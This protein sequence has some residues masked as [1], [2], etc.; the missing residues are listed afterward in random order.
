MEEQKQSNKI[1]LLHQGDIKPD[2]QKDFPETPKKTVLPKWVIILITVL[3]I[4][5]IGIGGY[6]AYQYYFVSEELVPC[7]MEVKLCPDGTG[8]GRFPPDCEFEECPEVID[9]TA[10]WQTYKNEEFGF[11]LKYPISLSLKLDDDND[12]YPSYHRIWLDSSNNVGGYAISVGISKFFENNLEQLMDDVD[13]IVYQDQGGNILADE[14]IIINQI[15]ARKIKHFESG[16][17]KVERTWI[18]FSNDDSY[19]IDIRA[20]MDRINENTFNQILSTFNLPTEK[21]LVWVEVD[22]VQCMENSWEIDWLRENNNDYGNYPRGHILV[23]EE[24]EKE[25]IKKY[26]QKQGIIIFN[27]K[28]E[29][30]TGDF[31]VCEACSCSQGYTLYLQ[32][33]ENDLN[34]I[35]GQDLRPGHSYKLF[36]TPDLDCE[37]YNYSNCPKGCHKQC[38][39]SNC[40]NG[41]NLICTDDC[42]GPESCV[43]LE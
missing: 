30:Y 26:Y 38:R 7:T 13:A 4:A 36:E 1:N 29:E 37:N 43:K 12:V 2:I 24:P 20:S 10:D 15:K 25:I 32:V 40:S 23:I 33:L 16:N 21:D 31:M 35:L 19:I 39:S 17:N 27:I 22:P 34:K 14:Q 8:V 41:P 6:F 42:D 5:I 9:P 11:E 3:V 18:R 28:S